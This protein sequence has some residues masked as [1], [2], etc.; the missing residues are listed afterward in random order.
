MM[1]KRGTQIDAVIELKVDDE[2]MV[3]RMETRVGESGGSARADDNPETLR[4][5]LSVY[6]KNAGSR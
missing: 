4:H 5:R 1:A 3:G 2:A 6:R